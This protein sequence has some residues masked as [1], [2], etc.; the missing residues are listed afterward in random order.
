MK[1]SKHNISLSRIVDDLL[2][3][4]RMIVLRNEVQNPMNSGGINSKKK[5]PKFIINQI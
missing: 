3:I 4:L 2:G 5:A 1:C